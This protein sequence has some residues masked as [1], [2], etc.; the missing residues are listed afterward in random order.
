MGIFK[1]IYYINFL[2][3]YPKYWE[4]KVHKAGHF[5]FLEQQTRIGSPISVLPLP[6]LVSYGNLQNLSLPLFTVSRTFYMQIHGQGI[7]VK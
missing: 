1:N 3:H 7:Q 4:I 6:S 2:T 5:K